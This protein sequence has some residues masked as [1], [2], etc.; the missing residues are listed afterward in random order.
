MLAQLAAIGLLLPGMQIG[1]LVLGG[2]LIA[3]GSTDA[4][5]ARMPGAP[6]TAGV[7]SGSA[8]RT[9]LPA[10]GL[11]GRPRRRPHP[12]PLVLRPGPGIR[13]APWMRSARG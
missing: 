13:H 3:L 6:G 4:R 12:S 9:G 2:V 1:F 7:G 5:R 10:E 8:A 11:S